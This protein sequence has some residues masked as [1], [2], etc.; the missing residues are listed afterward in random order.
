MTQKRFFVHI[1]DKCD[2]SETILNLRFLADKNK[3]DECDKRGFNE[4]NS[5]KNRNKSIVR[6]PQNSRHSAEMG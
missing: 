4:C 1:R 3:D 6:S 5:E 2:C